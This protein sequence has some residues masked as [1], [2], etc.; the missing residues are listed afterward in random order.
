MAADGPN[1]HCANVVS[2]SP[3][4][5]GE[6]IFSARARRSSLLFNKTWFTAGRRESKF[7]VTAARCVA[8]D[9]GED[10]TLS[11]SNLRNSSRGPE[12]AAWK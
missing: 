8:A 3:I 10:V 12:E 2:G 4:G 1:S 7:I 6:C 11:V 5:H 9:I